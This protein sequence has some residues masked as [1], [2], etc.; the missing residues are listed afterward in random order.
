MMHKTNTQEERKLIR[1]VEELPL[2]DEEK[3]GLAERIRNGEMSAELADEIRQKLTEPG[4]D[5]REQ[6]LRTRY[7][8]ELTMLVKRWRLSSQARNFTEK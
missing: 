8:A 5:E 4:S 6:S 7:L 1:L 2:P 3:N